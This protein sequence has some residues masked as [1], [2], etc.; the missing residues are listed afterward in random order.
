MSS[1]PSAGFLTQEA[2]SEGHEDVCTDLHGSTVV[3]NQINLSI[4]PSLEATQDD[5]LILRGGDAAKMH[6]MST[7]VDP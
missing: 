5:A 2:L 1:N 7:R 3:A 4:R 6:Y